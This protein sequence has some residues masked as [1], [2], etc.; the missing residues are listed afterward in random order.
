MKILPD[1]LIS[2]SSYSHMIPYTGLHG[3]AGGVQFGVGSTITIVDLL[4]VTSIP[5]VVVGLDMGGF[6]ENPIPSNPYPVGKQFQIVDVL[7]YPASW[8]LRPLETVASQAYVDSFID[9]HSP[10]SIRYKKEDRK[11]PKNVPDNLT[12]YL[13]DW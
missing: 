4:K 9:G 2:V 10:Y 11:R 13:L 6:I 3:L 1:G 5:E 8:V 7:G 12:E